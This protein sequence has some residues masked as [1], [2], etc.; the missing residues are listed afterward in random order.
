[1]F[2]NGLLLRDKITFFF[3]ICKYLLVGLLAIDYW[4]LA[5]GDWLFW[6]GHWLW[7]MG[8]SWGDW[9]SYALRRVLYYSCYT[10]IMLF[11]KILI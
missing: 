4:Q 6:V 10:I 7:A 11:A 8:Y 5:I 3:E 1:M 9:Q 2:S